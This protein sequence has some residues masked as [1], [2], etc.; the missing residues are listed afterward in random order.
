MAWLVGRTQRWTS[1]R[2]GS[3]SGNQV[4]ATLLIP[5]GA[6][7]LAEHLHQA[8]NNRAIAFDILVEA[9]EKEDVPIHMRLNSKE[10]FEYIAQQYP[11]VRE[12][13]ERLKLEI[14]Y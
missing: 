9:S 3:D 2:F 12:L 7:L 11:L 5:F 4:Q 6:Y 13:K 10:K 8:F 14:D 1:A